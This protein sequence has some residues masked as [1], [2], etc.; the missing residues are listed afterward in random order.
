MEVKFSINLLLLMIIEFR[1]DVIIHCCRL[2][3]R[4]KIGRYFAAIKGYIANKRLIHALKKCNQNIHIIYVSGS[5]MYG[6]CNEKKIYEDNHLNPLSFAK[7]YI[8]AEYPFLKT[9][10]HLNVTLCRPAWIVGDSSWFKTYYIDH[11]KT[12]QSIPCYGAG[13]NLMNLISIQSCASKIVNL[14]NKSSLKQVQNI[15]QF[16]SITQKQFCKSLAHYY[17][18]PITH[19]SHKAR[20]MSNAAYQ[21]FQIS[22]NLASYNSKNIS[23]FNLKTLIN[24]YSI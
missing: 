19:Y 5:L 14:I 6:D 21:A 11:I 15:V 1:P 23:K 13:N 9:Y 24:Q 10:Q 2:S 18:L 4:W 17:Q 20:Y 12:H 7:Q 3:G 16:E 22:C 8:I